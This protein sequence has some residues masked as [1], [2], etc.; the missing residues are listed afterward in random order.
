MRKGIPV[1]VIQF[2][3]LSI[4]AIMFFELSALST[5]SEV[6]SLALWTILAFGL[7][8]VV[9]TSFEVNFVD[10]HRHSAS[11]RSRFV[12]WD[13]MRQMPRNEIRLHF[14][15]SNYHETVLATFGIALGVALHAI[16]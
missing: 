3:L 9:G 8:F 14:L 13:V 6:I 12:N 4:S 11:S 15:S 7:F 1:A 10:S 2:S 16:V 5:T